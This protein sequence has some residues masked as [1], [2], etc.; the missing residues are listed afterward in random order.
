MICAFVH[1]ALDDRREEPRQ[2]IHACPQTAVGFGK[3]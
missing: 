2:L 3:L 1:N